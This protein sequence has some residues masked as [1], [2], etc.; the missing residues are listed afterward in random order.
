MFLESYR[1]NSKEGGLY[2]Q[3]TI[4][5]DTK[6]YE[7]QQILFSGVAPYLAQSAA[8]FAAYQWP[9]RDVKAEIM[10]AD[11]QFNP[12]GMP[13]FWHAW[14]TEGQVLTSEQIASRVTGHPKFCPYITAYISNEA[15]KRAEAVIKKYGWEKIIEVRLL[16]MNAS[17]L[18]EWDTTYYLLDHDPTGF[19]ARSEQMDIDRIDLFYK[20]SDGQVFLLHIGTGGKFE[21]R[22]NSE[23]KLQVTPLLRNH[24]LSQAGSSLWLVDRGQLSEV[25]KK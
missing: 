7:V 1:S 11:T 12:M 20:R 4:K 24:K 23:L 13:F 2:K 17:F 10:D 21:Q 8:A 22:K 5:V 18:S 15:H 9:P 3:T 19:V 16:G 14:L 25:L 6:E